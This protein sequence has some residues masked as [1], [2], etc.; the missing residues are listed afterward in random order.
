SRGTALTAFE[1]RCPLSKFLSRAGLTILDDDELFVA[2][3]DRRETLPL[4]H[5]LLVA[6][7]HAQFIVC[8]EIYDS[9]KFAALNS[10]TKAARFVGIE[11]DMATAIARFAALKDESLFAIRETKRMRERIVRIK[12]RN[13]ASDCKQGRGAGSARSKPLARYGRQPK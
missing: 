3:L 12:R 2:K 13:C 5:R 6:V 7:L 1:Q 9:A 11:V 8:S 10:Y 4:T